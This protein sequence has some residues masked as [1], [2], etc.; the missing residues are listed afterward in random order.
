VSTSFPGA[1]N[2]VAIVALVVLILASFI[3]LTLGTYGLGFGVLVVSWLVGYRIATGRPPI[4]SV[5]PA[6]P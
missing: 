3:P 2:W 6:S 5:S 4:E 1:L